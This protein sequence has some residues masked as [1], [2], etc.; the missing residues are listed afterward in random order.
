[1]PRPPPPAAPTDPRARPVELRPGVAHLARKVAGAAVLPLAIEYPFVGEKQPE[2][3]LSFGRV[4]DSGDTSR[5][6]AAWN[7]ALEAGLASAMDRL[8]QATASGPAEVF[9]ELSGGKRGVG[10]VYDLWRRAKAAVRGQRFDPS[11]T[12][13]V[14]GEGGAG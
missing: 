2:M 10:G 5:S 14:S 4:M 7:A 6:A 13:G 8:A 12:G 11:H 9:T 3:R 1:P